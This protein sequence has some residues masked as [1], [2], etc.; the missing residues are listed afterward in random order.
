M[1]CSHAAEADG[2]LPILRI[3]PEAEGHSTSASRFDPDV[4]LWRIC[5][6]SR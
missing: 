6:I 2:A 3:E 4:R 5:D 1:D